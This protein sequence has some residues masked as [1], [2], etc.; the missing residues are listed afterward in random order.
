MF[1]GICYT[2]G[3]GV[4]KDEAEAAECARKLADNPDREQLR[5]FGLALSQVAEKMKSLTQGLACYYGL[6]VPQD[7]SEAVKWF[8][9][10]ADLGQPEA[11]F[12]LGRCYADGQ[13]VPKDVVEAVK[14][15]R[16]AAEQ[17]LAEA[18]FNLGISYAQGD[19]VA[20]DY[21]EA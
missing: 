20:K 16:K 19:G 9:R 10:A 1:L 3:K 6:A 18:Q 13:G 21:V 14:W 12:Y 5:A 8:R 4:P 11:H 15:F 2:A 17:G 7:Y